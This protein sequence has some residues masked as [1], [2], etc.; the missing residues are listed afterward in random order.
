MKNIVGNNIRSRRQEL[1]ISQ[2]ELARR[3]GFK[4]KSAV[5]R[6][7]NGKEDLTTDRVIKYAEALECSPADLMGWGNL[8]HLRVYYNKIVKAFDEASEKDKKAICAIL[9]IPYEEEK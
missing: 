2:A 5:S 1:D 4:S 6:V 8:G 9:D 3:L 7:E